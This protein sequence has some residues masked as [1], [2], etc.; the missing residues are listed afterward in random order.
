VACFSLFATPSYR[1]PAKSL[2]IFS[3]IHSIF[4]YFK[5]CFRYGLLIISINIATASENIKKNGYNKAD[6]IPKV[7]GCLE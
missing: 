7:A 1:Y 5:T 2:E 6:Q 4:F 3:L